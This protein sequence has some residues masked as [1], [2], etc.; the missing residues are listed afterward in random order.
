MGLKKHTT[1]LL[2]LRYKPDHNG[3][4]KKVD[5]LCRGLSYL[6]SLVL[7]Y[8]HIIDPSIAPT[9]HNIRPEAS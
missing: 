1:G 7:I 2:V 5:K 8:L 4:S 3:L 6:H 9:T